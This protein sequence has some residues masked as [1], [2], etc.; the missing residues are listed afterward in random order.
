LKKAPTII[1]KKEH[2]GRK[3]DTAFAE[4]C[5]AQHRLAHASL[6]VP[7][8]VR[9]IKP[10]MKTLVIIRQTPEREGTKELE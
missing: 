7:R 4:N 1:Q 3:S 2:R 6:S 5:T 10:R 9:S 8:K